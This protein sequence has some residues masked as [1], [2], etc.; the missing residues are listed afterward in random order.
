MTILVAKMIAPSLRSTILMTKIVEGSL[1]VT[2]LVTKIGVR[3]LGKGYFS[4]N[5]V[6]GVS[7]RAF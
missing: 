4:R 1:P 7:V 5:R 2:F 3:S 6:T